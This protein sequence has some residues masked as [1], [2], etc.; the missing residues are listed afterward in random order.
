MTNFST[1]LSS[2]IEAKSIQIYPLTQYCNLD[3]STMYKYINGKRLPPRQELV[4]RI[5]DYMRLS[6]SEHDELL[7]AW[8]IALIGEE[9]YY[10]RKNAE[11]FILNFPDVSKIDPLIL[12]SF[13]VSSGTENPDPLSDCQ[14]LSS[15]TAINHAVSQT[16]LREAEKEDG[17]LALLLQP[18]NDYLFHFL[19][20]LGESECTLSIEQILCLNNSSQLDKSYHSLN[21]LYI[22]NELPLYIRALV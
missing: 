1:L 22:Q 11:N 5:A 9:D 2:F 6:P 14:A 3:R 10:N 17:R 19:T 15:Q 4:E 18:D 16:I 7:T 20:S 8:K 12:S 13:S 21:L